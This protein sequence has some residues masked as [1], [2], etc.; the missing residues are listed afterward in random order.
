MTKTGQTLLLPKSVSSDGI[1]DLI[2][3]NPEIGDAL[4]GLSDVMKHASSTEI[5]YTLHKLGFVDENPA[6]LLSFRE[7]VEFVLAPY[8]PEMG[9]LYDLH[10]EWIRVIEVEHPNDNVVIFAPIDSWKST[11]MGVNYL[12][13]MMYVTRGKVRIGSFSAAETLAKKRIIQCRE[14]IESNPRLNALGVR[15][16][17]DHKDWGETSFTIE[18][19]PAISGSTLAAF[20]IG[21]Q[22]QGFKFD[23]I[24]LDDVVSIENSRTETNR[25]NLEEKYRREVISRLTKVPPWPLKKSRAIAICTAFHMDDLNHKLGRGFESS[26]PTFVEKRYKAIYTADEDLT[27]APQFIRDQIKN[28]KYV[29]R[30]SETGALDPIGLI[31]PKRLTYKL[32]EYER[33]TGQ[34]P[35]F[36]AQNY[37]QQPLSDEDYVISPEDVTS[38]FDMSMP[39]GPDSWFRHFYGKGF[40]LYFVL[41]PSVARN[42]RQAEKK[43]TDF[44]VMEA[45]CY[46]KRLDLRVILDFRRGRGIKKDDLIREGIDFYNSF[47]R[48]PGDPSKVVAGTVTDVLPIWNVEDNAAQDY[49]VQDWEKIFGK[50]YVRG[51][52]TTHISKNDG[53]VGFPAIQSAYEGGRVKILAGDKRS[54]NYARLKRN[55]LCNFGVGG[56]KDDTVSV[57]LI[58]EQAIAKIRG[59]IKTLPNAALGFKNRGARNFRNIPTPKQRYRQRRA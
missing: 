8:Q 53:F 3:N 25:K 39:M 52:T 59:P 27:S 5:K 7:F 26:K 24:V 45:R 16:P 9:E 22:S 18:R 56:Y 15:K 54:V 38:C 50:T 4:S 37:Q 10:E 51:L 13:Y 1:Q 20:G 34:G 55:E 19:P 46:S 29:L 21:G 48:P 58:S 11:I 32:L 31:F 42:K 23:V 28:K 17:E 2:Q 14:T 6:M 40:V 43:K 35:K 41:D 30:N 33:T 44:F 12:L 57:D 36:F 49:L 47:L